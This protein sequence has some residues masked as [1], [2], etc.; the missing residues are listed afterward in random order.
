MRWAGHS[1]YHMS[2]TASTWSHSE[3]D[4]KTIFRGTQG[5]ST[6]CTQSLGLCHQGSAERF[7]PCSCLG[8]QRSPGL[9]SSLK[10]LHAPSQKRIK[11]TGRSWK[12]LSK[13]SSSHKVLDI[14]P[15]Q[16]LL[17]LTAGPVKVFLALVHSNW[18]LHFFLLPFSA[19]LALP[20]NANSAI[21]SYPPYNF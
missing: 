1:G 15:S 6:T 11:A 20:Y 19:C 18:S 21:L 10:S 3:T 9:A 16:I 2:T 5:I 8:S 7:L 12:L 14:F 4:V 17:S 13:Y